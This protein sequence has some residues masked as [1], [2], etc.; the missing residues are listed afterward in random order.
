MRRAFVFTFA[1][2][3]AGAALYTSACKQS[4]P[5]DSPVRKPDDKSLPT[6]TTT[7]APPKPSSG[8][9]RLEDLKS[10]HP[11]GATNPPSL[12]LIVST[13]GQCFGRWEGGMLPSKGDRVE[14]CGD[15]KCVGT[16]VQ[17]PP[18]AATLLTAYSA[19]P[20]VTTNPPYPKPTT[21]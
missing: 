19:A 7:N 3:A 12:Y 15:A 4:T 1:A 16:E 17:C 6:T 13:T 20:V 8:L 2:G 21:K 11:E 9:P 5:D 10:P 18:K 14:D